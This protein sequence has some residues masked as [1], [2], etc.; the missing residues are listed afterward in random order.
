MSEPVASSRIGPVLFVAAMA[1]GGSLSTVA[2]AVALATVVTAASVAAGEAEEVE[3][4]EEE[5]DDGII[6]SR[7]CDGPP[8]RL[9]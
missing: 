5:E 3:E 6:A 9:C 8:I 4:T 7:E 2:W 1:V